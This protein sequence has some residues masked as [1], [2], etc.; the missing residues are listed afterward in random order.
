M[1]TQVFAS[2]VFGIVAKN[3]GK[4]QTICASIR[5][6]S[7]GCQN[8]CRSRKNRSHSKPSHRR[9]HT[10]SQLGQRRVVGINVIKSLS[11]NQ[12]PLFLLWLEILH[13]I[14]HQLLVQHSVSLPFWGYVSY[15]Q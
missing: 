4:T 9:S 7:Q 15:R 8:D 13:P 2:A 1:L 14:G 12:S 5:S 11:S 3:D 6:H 10:I